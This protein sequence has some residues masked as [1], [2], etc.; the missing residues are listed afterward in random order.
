MRHLAAIF[1]VSLVALAACSTD[2]AGGF[3]GR[4]DDFAS[5]AHITASTSVQVGDSL[6][7][8]LCSGPATG[9]RWPQSAT[10]DDPSIVKQGSHNFA[11]T[12]AFNSEGRIEH[13]ETWAF[14]AL[15]PGK[16]TVNI[17]STQ[18]QGPAEAG[19]WTYRLV[20]TVE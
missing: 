15:K 12:D 2:T 4:C 8:S 18:L 5:Q 19:K 16:A 14:T 7:V 1:L 11:A 20:V 13:F 6:S 3:V 17:D 10:I 9:V